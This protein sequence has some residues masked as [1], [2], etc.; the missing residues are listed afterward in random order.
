MSIEAYVTP[1]ESGHSSGFDLEK[2]DFYRATNPS[3]AGVGFFMGQSA[4]QPQMACDSLGARSSTRGDSRRITGLDLLHLGFPGSRFMRTRLVQSDTR[5][6][7][8]WD[9]APTSHSWRES[10]FSMP[11]TPARPGPVLIERPRSDRGLRNRPRGPAPEK[12]GDPKAKFPPTNLLYS[13]RPRNRV[14]YSMVFC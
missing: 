5:L 2:R 8:H 13:L 3:V 12:P 6:L 14:W 9:A 1:P 11:L 4:P 10:C 7:C